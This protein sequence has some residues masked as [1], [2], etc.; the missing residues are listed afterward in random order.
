MITLVYVIVKC[1][2]KDLC[3]NFQFEK[4]MTDASNKAFEH[5]RLFAVKQHLPGISVAVA[6]N[7]DDPFVQ[8]MLFCIF[9]NCIL[10]KI[11][12]KIFSIF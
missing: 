9:N 10:S 6:L 8:C 7:D 4:I 5:I 2:L 3:I 1:I 12:R 11:E